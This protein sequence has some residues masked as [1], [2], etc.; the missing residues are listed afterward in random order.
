MLKLENLYKRTVTALILGTIFFG[1]FFLSINL[2][3]L[4]LAIIAILCLVE[5]AQLI[6]KQKLI[7]WILTPIYPLSSFFLMIS[8]NNS[9][10]YLLLILFLSVAIFDTAAYFVGSMMGKR[11]ILPKISPKKSW[12]GFLGG[13]FALIISFCLLQFYFKNYVDVLSVI[14]ISLVIAVLAVSGDMFESWFKRRAGVKDSGKLLP[15]HGGFL[16]RFDAVIFVAPF[17]YLFKEF[18]AGFFL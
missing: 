13:L 1:T 6:A 18:L 15:G 5:W 17:F 7:F 2:F 12:E 9:D 10:R 16:D 14:F 8:L 3:T 4:L 11:P